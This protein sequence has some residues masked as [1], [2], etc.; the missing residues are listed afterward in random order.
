MGCLH[1]INIM[2]LI[3]AVIISSVMLI[4]CSVN[5][6]ETDIDVDIDNDIDIP[7]DLVLYPP[8]DTV[9]VSHTAWTREHYQVRIAEFKQDPINPNSIVML[10]NSLTEQGGDW[11]E[12]LDQ[13]MVSNRGIAG[14]NSDGLRARLGEI[15]C[16]KPIAVFVMI[17]TNDLWTSYSEN[18]VASKIN[19]IGSYLAENLNDSKIYIQTIMP[20]GEG[21]DRNNRLRNINASLKSFEQTN[22]ILID[23]WELM[24]DMNGYLASN[25]TTDGVHL[26]ETGYNKWV[27]ILK[28]RL[29]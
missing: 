26:T 16:A 19:D 17:G 28:E 23:T 9:I 8:A 4:A 7:C 20:I 25:L 12:R 5:S 2:Q 6:H 10:G 21:N 24:S 15:I 13:E 11:G 3:F 29:E 22:Y 18:E 1:K 27:E 14:D